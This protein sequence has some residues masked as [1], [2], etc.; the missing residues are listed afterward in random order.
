LRKNFGI[1]IDGTVTC[2]TTFI[3]YLNQSFGLNLTLDDIKEYDLVPAVK[4]TEQELAKWFAENE[5]NIYANAPLAQNAQKVLN[6]WKHQHELIYISAR[7]KHLLD[8]TQNW[9]RSND[10]HFHHIDLVGSHDKIETA[11]KHKIDVFFEDKHDNACDISEECDIPVILFD[12]PYNRL[13]VP[14]NVIRVY[15]WMEAKQW[16]D[17][18]FNHPNQ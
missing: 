15:D 14:K 16:I 18:W 7:H 12:T 2:P 8:I 6:E 1:D 11:K 4:V 9:F 5:A 10:I 17:H 3:P 13:P